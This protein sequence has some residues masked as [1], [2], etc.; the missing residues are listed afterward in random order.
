MKK[1]LAIVLALVLCLSLVA[2]VGGGKTKVEA[3]IEANQ[4]VFSGLSSALS[5]S[6]GMECSAE[7]T[8][9]GNGIIV[10]ITFE[11][12]TATAFLN[13]TV[14]SGLESTLQPTVDAQLESIQEDLAEAES[15]TYNIYDADGDLLLSV[16]SEE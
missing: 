1:L 12:E 5:T 8:A 3:Y 15:L 13:E 11:D 9:E 4:D 7:I 14:L 10:S 6:T 2:C 16:S